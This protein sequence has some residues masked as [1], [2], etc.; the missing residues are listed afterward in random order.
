MKNKN[1]VLKKELGNFHYA[2]IADLIKQVSLD[3]AIYIVK[4]LE[5]IYRLK[6]LLK[7]MKVLEKE[8]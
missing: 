2:D 5:M 8:L 1:K 6:H 4:L 7:L 3:E